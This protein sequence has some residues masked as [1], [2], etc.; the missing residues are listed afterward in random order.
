VNHN[1]TIDGYCYRLRPVTLDD[2]AFIVKLRTDPVRSKYINPISDDVSLQ[3]DWLN[4][5]FERTGDYYFVVEH[6]GSRK[7]EGLIS[8]YDVSDCSAEWG[9]WI[10]ETGSSCAIESAMLVYKLAFENFSLARVF[11]RTLEVNGSVLSFHDSSGAK[12]SRR[13]ENHV[14]IDNVSYSAIE[15][16]LSS[17]T[18]EMVNQRLDSIAYRMSRKRSD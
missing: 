18:W 15:H 12:R 6:I 7:P 2:A 13:I 17:E 10:T 4:C 9:R 11:C 16:E 8:L 5:Y 1:F 14:I 3:I